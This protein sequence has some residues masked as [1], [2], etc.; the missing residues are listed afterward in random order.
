[1]GL[2][3]AP[4]AAPRA[5]PSRGEGLDQLTREVTAPPRWGELSST[6]DGLNPAGAGLRILRLA[7]DGAQLRVARGAPVAHRSSLGERCRLRKGSVP[8]VLPAECSFLP[9]CARIE[10]A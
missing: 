3:A 7:A 10:A 5:D 9:G 1:M 2:P 4:G 8:E 6:Q